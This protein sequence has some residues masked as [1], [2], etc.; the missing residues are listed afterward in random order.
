MSLP[1]ITNSHSEKR[2][3][4][5]M[6]FLRSLLAI[7]KPA[8]KL[9]LWV[10]GGFL[11]T[12]ALGAAVNHFIAQANPDSESGKVQKKTPDGIG[13]NSRVANWW[14]PAAPADEAEP[15]SSEAPPANPVSPTQKSPSTGGHR[16]QF[17]AGSP[18]LRD[19]LAPI[20][21]NPAP[22]S[23]F[24][25]RDWAKT[26]ANN[27]PPLRSASQAIPSTHPGIPANHSAIAPT[28]KAATSSKETAG[29][30][31]GTVIP[32][33]HGYELQAGELFVA[34]KTSPV[35]ANPPQPVYAALGL[36]SHG[37]PAPETA[38][39]PADDE[40]HFSLSAQLDTVPTLSISEDILTPT[41]VPEPGACGMLAVGAVMLTLRRRRGSVFRA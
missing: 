39:G 38:Q 26:I 20:G 35:G 12:T 13:W 29:T 17:S 3:S 16:P 9:A 34:N 19:T 5:T 37:A 15:A 2:I 6:P 11:V 22:R 7:P 27:A 30:R 28:Q 40:L 24:G 1:E 21:T 41:A 10:V 8:R 4:R 33:D 25:D 18:V 23:S 31:T 14:S 32:V 36:G